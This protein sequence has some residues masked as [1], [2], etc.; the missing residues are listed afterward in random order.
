MGLSTEPL[1]FFLSVLQTGLIKSLLEALGGWRV[2]RMC[3]C[4]RFRRTQANHFW[5]AIIPQQERPWCMLLGWQIQTLNTQNM[6]QENRSP[7][8]PCTDFPS[9]AFQSV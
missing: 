2:L 6:V 7:A 3:W 9:N 1:A 4:E 8:F 5:F